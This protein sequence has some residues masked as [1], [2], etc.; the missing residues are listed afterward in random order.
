M[1]E[2]VEVE[3]AVVALRIGSAVLPPPPARPGGELG[4]PPAP[5][6]GIG[7]AEVSG[8]VPAP[9]GSERRG[10]P[11][12]PPPAPIAL[13]H[14]LQLGIIRQR[15]DLVIDRRGVDPPEAAIRCGDDV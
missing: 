11:N 13:D 3:K 7:Q 15:R 14:R 4:P 9:P 12:A 1:D 10:G 2:T 8:G 5:H 6:P